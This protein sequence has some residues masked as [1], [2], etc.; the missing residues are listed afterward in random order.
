MICHNSRA[1]D[2]IDIKLGPVTKFS[3]IKKE[4]SKK[5]DNNV[6][7]ANCDFIFFPIYG[8]FEPILKPDS[9]HIVCKTY[10]FIN[11]NHLFTIA[12]NGTKKS[13]P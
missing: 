1:S 3:K 13:L 11:N 8:Q 9:E 5:I 12:E 6:T 2:N 4:L 7:S 10:I